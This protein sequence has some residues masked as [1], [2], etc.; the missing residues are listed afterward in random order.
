VS[1]DVLGEGRYLRLKRRGRWEYVERT[2]VTGVVAIVAVTDD[3][4][5][6]L[7][8]QER[9]PVQGRVIEIPAGLAGDTGEGEDELEDAARRELEEE[10]GFRAER[11]EH[12]GDLPTSAGLTTEVMSVYRATGLERVSAGGGDTTENIKVHLVPL[13]E[14][15]EWIAARKDE[16]ALVDVKLYAGLYFARRQ[17]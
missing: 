8:E 6:V 10:T 1:E 12:L 9:V 16:G 7:V 3:G 4:R 13:G 11:L 2:N 5:I 17:G 15:D 14:V